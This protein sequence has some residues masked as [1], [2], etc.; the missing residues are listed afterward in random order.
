MPRIIPWRRLSNGSA[1]SST[2]S[3]V[4]AAPVAR[5]PAP[6]HSSSVSEVTSS[7]ATITTRRQRPARIQSSASATAWVVLAQAAL[8]C[9][10]GPARADEL[11]ELR[12]AHRQDAEQEAA[13]ELERLGLELAAS[14]SPIRRSISAAASPPSSVGDADGAQRRPARCAA[15]PVGDV[16]LD[17][18]GELAVAREGRGEDHAGVVAQRVGQPPA[19][20]QLACPTVVVL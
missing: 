13:V 10:F 17:V 3:S 1:A 7:A 16:A 8:T 6:I 20:G 11:G 9:V 19:L 12:V 4:A 14:I 5:K 2:T 18:G 15:D